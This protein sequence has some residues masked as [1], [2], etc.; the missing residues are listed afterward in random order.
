MTYGRNGRVISDSQVDHPLDKKLR[1]R[2]EKIRMTAPIDKDSTKGEGKTSKKNEKVNQ[3]FHFNFRVL[4]VV[5]LVAP[6]VLV[7]KIPNMYTM[8]E[9]L[10]L[11]TS[12]VAYAEA[13]E[14]RGSE[15][16]LS[17]IHI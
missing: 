13:Q 17:L 9:G 14:T 16:K 6:L 11:D 10:L 4:P 1:E 2:I 3:N 12:V 8:V 7:I 15:I 5:V